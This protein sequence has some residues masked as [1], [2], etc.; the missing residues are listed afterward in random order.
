MKNLLLI[1]LLFLALACREP[2]VSETFIRG[3]GPFVFSVDMSDSTAAYSFDIYSR[4][5]RQ[6]ASGELRLLMRWRSPQEAE[7]RETVY[8]PLK[9]H[10]S[11]FSSEAYAPYRA[12]VRPS[13]PGVWT[14]T[15]SMPDL[16]REGLRGMGL[17]VRKSE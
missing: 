10:T 4:V 17:V 8:L 1:L 11:F 6:R 13:V 3:D 9:G 12:D 16:Q 15:V 7:F 5:D 2:R 14:L